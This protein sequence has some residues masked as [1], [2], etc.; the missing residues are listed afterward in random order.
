MRLKFFIARCKF[1]MKFHPPFRAAF[2]QFTILLS[3]I[4]TAVPIAGAQWQK[5][6]V[7]TKASLRGLSVV[8]EK[9]VWASGTGGT[10]LKTIDG[11]K[12]WIV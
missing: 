9:I 5:Q 8:S 12:N 3:I 6:T 11:G 10:F 7:D 1:I 4:F 2:R